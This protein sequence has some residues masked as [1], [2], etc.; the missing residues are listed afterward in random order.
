MKMGI[1]K[2][3]ANIF[4]NS[5]KIILINKYYYRRD[6]TTLFHEELER[7]GCIMFFYLQSLEHYF[8]RSSSVVD[9]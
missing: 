6:Q 3:L 1:F 4:N 7:D 9:V 2:N 5:Y 8:T